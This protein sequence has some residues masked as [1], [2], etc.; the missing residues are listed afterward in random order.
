[1]SSCHQSIPMSKIEVHVLPRDRSTHKSWILDK[2]INQAIFKNLS[3]AFADKLIYLCYF[4]IA[5]K[6]QSYQEITF[7]YWGE[8]PSVCVRSHLSTASIYSRAESKF[9]SNFTVKSHSIV[10]KQPTFTYSKR[11]YLSTYFHFQHIYN[12]LSNFSVFRCHTYVL[13]VIK[14]EFLREITNAFTF[15]RTWNRMLLQLSYKSAG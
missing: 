11:N 1:M 15:Q 10:W 7:L 9:C 14:S 4:G 8:F 2:T 12:N 6:F 3:E 13:Q 5:A